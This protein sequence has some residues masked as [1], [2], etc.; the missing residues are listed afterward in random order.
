MMFNDLILDSLMALVAGI[1]IPF[2]VALLLGGKPSFNNPAFTGL[3]GVALT[4]TSS[5]GMFYEW[6]V[7]I[8]IVMVAHSLY[9]SV[10]GGD[11]E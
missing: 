2:L 9:T 3:F 8:G 7:I 6:G 11:A 4:M 1:G 10:R 5:M